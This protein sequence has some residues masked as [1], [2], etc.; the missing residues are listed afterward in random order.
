MLMRWWMVTDLWPLEQ[1][2]FVW[3]LDETLI[4]F[5]SFLNG[6]WA[7]AHPGS[8]ATFAA[9]LGVAWSNAIYNFCDDHLFFQQ[10]LTHCKQDHQVLLTFLHDLKRRNML[11]LHMWHYQIEFPAE[12]I[13]MS[14]LDCCLCM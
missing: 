10:V 3:D 2:V 4:V 14:L 13:S 8:N 1:V 12:Y 9:Q 11:Q 6:A 5:N 7:A